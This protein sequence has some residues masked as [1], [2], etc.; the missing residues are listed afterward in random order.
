MSFNPFEQHAAIL[1]H[2]QLLR[3]LF[4]SKKSLSKRKSI[5]IFEDEDAFSIESM[6]PLE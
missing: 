5:L 6:S 3:P 4:E 2:E 1:T